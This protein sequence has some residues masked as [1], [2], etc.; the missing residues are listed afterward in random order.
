M[1]KNLLVGIGGRARHSKALYVGVGGKARK[2]KKVYVGVGGKARLVYQSYIPVTGI[3][4]ASVSNYTD[5]TYTSPGWYAK[6]TILFTPSNAT[7]KTVT[8]SI[9]KNGGFN[10]SMTIKKTTR[11]SCIITKDV[12]NGGQCILLV[13]AADG[14]QKY[15]YCKCG[16][17]NDTNNPWHIYEVANANGF[18]DT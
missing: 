1:G 14:Q 9:A 8:W 3:S 17:L 2:V 18:P 10:N 11:D 4:F 7:N 5:S 15:I 6:I 13:K 12:W 16:S